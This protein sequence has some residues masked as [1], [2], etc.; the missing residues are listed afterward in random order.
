MDILIHT[1]GVKLTDTLQKAITRKIGRVR[2]YAPRATRARVQLHKVRASPSP[3][4]FTVRVHYEIPG[5]DLHAEH[6]AHDPVVALD[7]VAEKAERR[8]RKTKTARLARRMRSRRISNDEWTQMN[9]R[10]WNE[11]AHA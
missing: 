1:N 7:L 4:Q 10:R 5:N 3:Q 9:L 6:S 11:F 2:Q 8:L